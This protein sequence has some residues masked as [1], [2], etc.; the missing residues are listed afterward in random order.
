MLRHIFLILGFAGC[1]L[2]YGQ[3]KTDSASRHMQRTWED[4]VTYLSE[5]EELAEDEEWQERLEEMEELTLHPININTATKAD[6]LLVPL[7]DET[8]ATEI[9]EYIDRHNGMKTIYELVLIE[10]IPYTTR[11]FLPLFLYV[12]E[13][14][15]SAKKQ[16]T[17]K[18][19]L[20]EHHHELLTRFDIPLYYR[21]GYMRKEGYRGSPLYNKTRYSFQATNHI[22]ASLRMERDP[23]ERGIDSYGGQLSLHNLGHLNTLI[24]GDYRVSFGEGLVINQ[25]M[26]FGKN[27]LLNIPNSGIRAHN[28]TDEINFMRG[29][30]SS[31]QWGGW[32][33]AAFASYRC[34]DGTLQGDTCIKT[35]QKTGYHRTS[36]EWNNKGNVE[37]LTGGFHLGWKNRNWSVGASGYAM[38]T[39]L[40]LTRGKELY[41][42]INPEGQWQSSLGVD[43]AYRSYRWKIHGETAY[44]PSQGGIATLNNINW[45]ATN[46]YTISLSQRYYNRLYYSHF[47]RAISENTNVQNETG[48]TI[49]LDAVPIDGL[50]LMVFGDFFYNPWPRYGLTHS[51]AGQEGR[52]EIQYDAS[53]KHH[54]FLR[55]NI[56]NKEVSKG[57]Q[58]Q[59]RILGQWTLQGTQWAFKTSAMLHALKGSIGGAIG[60]TVHYIPGKKWKAALGT[61]YFNT[62]DY[63]SRIYL[64]EPG[65]SQ[66]MSMQS[67]Y[68]QGIRIAGSAQFHLWKDHIRLEIKYGYTQYLDGRKTQGTGLQT[69]HSNCKNDISAQLKFKI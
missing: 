44:S 41:R 64:Y 1:I 32:N 7:L 16:L 17:F 53:R 60:E 24:V 67:F 68:G 34:V 40:P 39:S 43:Y 9:R 66:A 25:G 48:V 27:T 22:T 14:G 30:A 29:I 62:K 58:L 6:L 63:D 3:A 56:K 13:T 47:A 51:S 46:R 36:S 19:M 10:S 11:S 12:G 33:V 42:Q 37:A 26:S 54:F 23:G 69:I 4:F 35:L 31:L 15:T 50:Q 38:H 55:Y 49:K 21:E 61:C 8:Q 57:Q 65:I 5:N 52:F 2:A 59:H 28:G 20:H 18:E 45:K